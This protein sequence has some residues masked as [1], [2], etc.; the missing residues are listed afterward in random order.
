[1]LELTYARQGIWY[2]ALLGNLQQCFD[3]Y[4]LAKKLQYLT[5]RCYLVESK[6]RQLVDC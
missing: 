3:L 6:A 5:P 1:M 2:V 4:G